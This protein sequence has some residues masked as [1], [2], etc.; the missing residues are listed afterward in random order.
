MSEKRQCPVHESCE[1]CLLPGAGLG[2]HLLELAARCGQSHTYRI[3]GGL[4]AITMRNCDRH[5]RLP[6]GEA[7]GSPQK[8]DGGIVGPI[9]INNKDD[10]AYKP[11]GRV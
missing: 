6:M 1:F 3:G 7:E 5:L 9:W 8:I 11:N 4:E 2:K 10:A